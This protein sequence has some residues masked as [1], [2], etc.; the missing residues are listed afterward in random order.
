MT[1][2]LVRRHDGDFRAHGR[3]FWTGDMQAA[4]VYPK[5]GPAKAL[6]TKWQRENPDEP[7]LT[8]LMLTFEAYDMTVV[9]MSESTSKAIARIQRRKL[10]RAQAHAKSEMEELQRRHEQILL[11]LNTLNF[12]KS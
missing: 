12:Q 10:E 4:R 8:L 6:I 5:P 1:I 7:T 9:D 11:R 2:Y 3:V